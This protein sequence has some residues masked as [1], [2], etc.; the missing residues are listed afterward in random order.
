M[1]GRHGRLITSVACFM[2]ASSFAAT[3]PYAGAKACA[4]CHPAE[5]G[6]QALSA[7]AAALFRASEHPLK[8]SFPVDGKL[9]RKPNYKFEFFRAGGELRT[10]ILD[11]ANVMDLPMEWAFGAGRQAVTF[12]TRVD[13]G[14]YVEHYSTYYSALR[15]W[16]ATPGQDAI[17]P[18][19]LPQAAGL[20]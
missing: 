17:H 19:S 8:G 5:S 4:G 11:A 16:G 3:T 15:S 13:K 2:A 14:W 10:R 18:T 1:K 9:T 7:H 20:L 12:V 6:R